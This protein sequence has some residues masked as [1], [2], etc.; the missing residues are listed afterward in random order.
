MRP[1]AD[2][3]GRRSRKDLDAAALTSTAGLAHNMPTSF[4]MA[5]EDELENSSAKVPG[6]GSDST[7]GVR[8]LQETIYEA[9]APIKTQD[10]DEEDNEDV[11]DGHE[12]RRR[13]TLRPKP[14]F[15]T[16]DSSRGSVE[17]APINTGDSSPSNP[18]QADHLAPSLSQSFASLSSQAPLSSMPSSPKSFSNRSFRPSDE[19]SMDE[20][21]SQAVASSEDDDVEPQSQSSMQDSAPQLI[22]PSIKMPSRRPFTERGKSLGRLKVLIAGDSGVGKTSLIKSI[23]QTCED[24]VHVDP[25]SPN[26]LSIDQLPSRKSKS[27]PSSANVR[28][29][30]KIKEVYASTKPYP[31]WWSDIEETKVLRRRKSMGDT[32]LER[33]LCFVDTPGYSHGMSRTECIESILHYVEAQLSKPFADTVNI[34]GSQGDF[35]SLLDG[36]GGSQVDVVLYMI[37]TDLKDEDIIFLQRLATLTNIVPLIAKSD[38]LSPEETEVL[39]RSTFQKLQHAD[40]RPFTFN[41]ETTI[42]SHPYTVCAAPSDDNENMDA[43]MLMSSGYV[44]PLIP[45]ELAILVQQIFDQDNISCMRHLAARKLVRAQGSK[46][47]TIPTPF[48]C[49]TSNLVHGHPLASMTSTA[50]SPNTSQPMVSYTNSMSPYAQARIADHTQ[51]EEK[52]AQIRL[53]RW[54]GELQRSLQNERARYEAISRGE[55]AVWLTEKIGECINDGSLVPVQDSSL[56][57]RTEKGLEATK[58]ELRRVSGHR[59]LLDP[60][61]PLGLVRWNEV[62]K[63]KGWIAF[64]VVGSVGIL[65]AMAV[66]VWRTWGSGDDG[67]MAATWNWGWLAGRA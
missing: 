49:P 43:S 15:R 64:Q 34:G 65:G 33:N 52:L 29:T 55:R 2:V 42:L 31:T 45:S 1:G 20:G 16:R 38:K 8:S 44:Q 10:D 35:V 61:D 17:Q 54:A 58:L 57:A 46:A 50:Y 3:L 40:I 11:G 37:D 18:S 27:K 6:P 32:V 36:S 51:Q 66:W 7:F 9:S 56:A 47:L 22:M 5:N 26:L 30:N 62:L 13:S 14:K 4:R 23:V 41:G 48:P 53:A 67:Y 24:I 19:D 25:L 63:K 60:G 12:G 21:G 39:K 59:G 28:S